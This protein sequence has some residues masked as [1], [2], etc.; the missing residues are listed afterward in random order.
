MKNRVTDILSASVLLCGVLAS[1]LCLSLAACKRPGEPYSKV[2]LT[3][4]QA[5]AISA[6]VLAT[7]AEA[8]DIAL[9]EGLCTPAERNAAFNELRLLLNDAGSL[10]VLLEQGTL[11]EKGDA[12]KL[13]V[14]LGHTGRIF[15]SLLHLQKL[16]AE[17]RSKIQLAAAWVTRLTDATRIVIAALQPQATAPKAAGVTVAYKVRGVPL[18]EQKFT[19]EVG[20]LPAPRSLDAGLTRLTSL[21]VDLLVRAI[22]LTKTDLATARKARTE[23][24][25]RLSARLART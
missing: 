12:D 1:V 20:D 22:Q 10:G 15:A 17:T 5:T 8:F 3:V 4:A 18:G 16:P 11:L 13:L 9:D 6:E 21:G 19:V 24:F 25:V 14:W 23:A 2:T 7:T